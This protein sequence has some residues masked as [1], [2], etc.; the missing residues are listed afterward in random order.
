MT[1]QTEQWKLDG[2][3]KEC[4][5]KNYC[6]KYCSKR[7]RRINYEINNAISRA[8]AKRIMTNTKED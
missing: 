2:N 3:C 8:L 7:K 5:R 1:E 4:R 6:K